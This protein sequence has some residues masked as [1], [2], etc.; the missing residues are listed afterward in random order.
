MSIVE[1]YIRISCQCKV[2]LFNP[3]GYWD[4]EIL[5]GYWKVK[6]AKDLNDANTNLKYIYN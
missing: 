2:I 6:E 3:L 1:D 4:R 5:N